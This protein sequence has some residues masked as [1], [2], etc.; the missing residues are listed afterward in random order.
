MSWLL[1]LLL[2]KRFIPVIIKLEIVDVINELSKRFW[3]MFNIDTV[4][5]EEVLKLLILLMHHLRMFWEI[6]N[7]NNTV[8]SM[9]VSRNC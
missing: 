9:K 3:E 8:L 2:T 4:L 1:L 7:V 6:F 5:S